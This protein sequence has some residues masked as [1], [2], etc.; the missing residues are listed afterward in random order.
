M[1]TRST[2]AA[3]TG[4]RDR[5]CGPAGPAT[6]KISMQTTMRSH[7]RQAPGNATG[8]G[9]SGAR[10]TLAA[11]ARRP[12]V[13]RMPPA[14]A[15]TAPRPARLEL[16]TPVQFLPGV[17]PAR[18]ALLA[19]LGITTVERLL[20]HL[21]REYVDA[22]R[23][24]PIGR[25]ARAGA[26][27]SP[28]SGKIVAS[29]VRNAHGRADLR[30]RVAD[31]TGTLGATWFG[32]GFLQR[33]LP[34]GAVVA[35]V[36]ELA[37]GP[38]L[39][40]ANPLFEV[41]EGDDAAAAGERG[42]MIPRYALTA[43]VSARLLTG[44]IRAA[45][46]GV[47]AGLDAADPLPAAVRESRGLVCR[48]ARRCARRTL[49]QAPRTRRWRAAASPSRS[50]SCRSSCSRSGVAP[51][52]TRRRRCRPRADAARASAVIAALPFT[53]TDAQK[54]VVNEIVRDM[55]A[56][57]SMH[58]LLV[59]D[60]GSGKTVVALLAAA[61]A[62]EAGFQVAVMAPTEILA[63]QHFRDAHRARQGGRH[64][65]RA[66][67]RLDR[68]RP[69]AASTGG[70]SRSPRATRPRSIARRR[71]ARAARGRTCALPRLGAR[72]RRRAAPLR[73]APARAAG[74]EGRGLPG[75]AGH[76][77]DADPAHASRWPAFGDLDV[78]VLDE[79]PEGPQADRHP[80]RR[81]GE[82]ASSVYAF[83]AR[84]LTR[85][86]AGLRRGPAHRGE[87]GERPARRQGARAE[88]ARSTRCSSA[89]ASAS[90]HG[91]LK[92]AEKERAS[93]APSPR[94]SSTRSWPRP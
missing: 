22:R 74:E 30:A 36:G 69:R 16:D 40:F 82:R 79:L 15:P 58:R 94:A 2:C 81:R 51:A 29:E 47:G 64:R 43:G 88:P 60:V 57:R 87:R 28:S 48:A 10:P 14:S 89:F 72:R 12:Y 42:R 83:L 52:R 61:C 62:I 55:Q 31:A 86:A 1:E 25:L 33:T 63:E 27:P 23:V 77:R 17:G 67:D 54:R 90:L 11:R 19:R 4:V 50:C 78:S 80:G 5:G 38:G 59:G 35:L 45:L 56:P 20:T 71:H 85:R 7:A 8:Q 73:R 66:V 3:R 41:L 75:R 70:A 93:C 9:V 18:A 84:E 21:P 53:A 39:G 76:D 46:A 91:R 6:R 37:P 26:G 68:A 34:V 65:A 49:R 32:Q 13:E 92:S 44:W 24:V